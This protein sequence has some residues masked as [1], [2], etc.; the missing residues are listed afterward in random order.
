VD[1]GTL[2]I[3][4]QE[5]V[6]DGSVGIGGIV[7]SG[8]DKR[9][10]PEVVARVLAEGAPAGQPLD[11]EA[12]ERSL[13]VANEL[14]GVKKIKANLA[15]GSSPAP[16]RWKPRWR[17][18]GSSPAACGPTTTVTT[19][20]AA[21]AWS[22]AANLNS[23]TG[24]GDLWTLT[25]SKSSGMTSGRFGAIVPVGS[26]GGRVG[27]SYSEVSMDFA[28][29]VIPV[30]LDGKARVASVFA[31]YPLH[32]SATSNVLLSGSYD[33]K[34][35]QH[36]IEG[37]TDSDRQ[38]SLFTLG[39]LGDGLDRFGGT[40]SWNLSLASG[41]ADL[42][43]NAANAL[44]DDIGAR[45]DGHFTK[46]NYAVSR[47]APIGGA[48]SPW[49]WY[50]ASA[51][52]SPATT[53]TRLR[54]SSSAAPTACAPTRSARPSAIPATWRTSSC[55][56]AWAARRWANSRCW[57]SSTWAASPST[58]TPGAAGA[59]ATGPTATRSRATASAPA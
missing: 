55:A 30:N 23:P 9:I 15:P 8:A 45:T 1:G 28:G 22:V 44:R 54:S 50:A 14:P 13:L 25:A 53:S 46:T 48:G 18:A 56:A 39:L 36:N 24:Y 2:E 49:S 33:A 40:Y 37:S 17:R 43:G 47:L 57:A 12:L 42:S 52:S 27:A 29:Q 31:S 41:S 59:P 58:T 21:A 32:R 16:P 38:I 7:T 34:S 20:P 5:G 10:R 3:R 11:G 26:R 35:L 19:T 51:G 4:V 6:V